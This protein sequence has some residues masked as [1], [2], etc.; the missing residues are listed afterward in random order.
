MNG[1]MIPKIELNENEKT[2]LLEAWTYLRTNAVKP[3]YQYL[4]KATIDKTGAQFIP[5][6][7]SPLLLNERTEITFLG[8]LH[9]EPNSDIFKNAEDL[10][11][12][13][14]QKLRDAE[15]QDTF[16]MSQLADELKIDRQYARI[17]FA[18]LTEFG[19]VYNGATSQ[20]TFKGKFDYDQYTIK[21]DELFE[22]YMAFEG[23]EKKMEDYYRKRL[24]SSNLV[25]SELRLGGQYLWLDRLG[26]LQF[27]TTGSGIL[28]NFM[29]RSD[30]VFISPS[31][32]KQIIE[33]KSTDFDFL[34]LLHLCKEINFNYLY[35]N[36]YGV[37]LLTRAL[38]DHIPPIFACKNFAE[39]ANNYK[40][41]RNSQSFK[42][43]MIH[44][45]N[46]LRNIGDSLI[47]SQIRKREISP[48]DVQIDFKNDLDVLLSEIVRILKS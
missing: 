30:R 47:H 12:L 35:E 3:D 32:I 48:N 31:R 45:D 11:F 40:S 4:R 1:L 41:D 23:L 39:V 21:S 27:L 22:E 43:A 5:T 2:W 36:Y 20:G 46:S 17:I 13:I 9:I 42:K 37:A 29:L 14:K 15:A 10:L 25:D 44:L 19:N 24:K 16:L 33:I 7:I 34:K 28:G 18:L 6:T 26:Q 38:I 8:V